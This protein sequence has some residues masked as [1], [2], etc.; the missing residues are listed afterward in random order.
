MIRKKRRFL[1]QTEEN[2][3]QCLVEGKFVWKYLS[4]KV[5]QK[6]GRKKKLLE[7]LSAYNPTGEYRFFSPFGWW[8]KGMYSDPLDQI[9]S[10]SL[11]DLITLLH[12]PIRQKKNSIEPSVVCFFKPWFTNTHPEIVFPLLFCQ[13]YIPVEACKQ[14]ASSTCI[15]HISN[16][17]AISDII[18]TSI[19]TDVRLPLTRDVIKKIGIRQRKEKKA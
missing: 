18:P 7:E 10:N 12:P 13:F 8:T 15:I 1:N 11:S 4:N 2:K 9:R 6:A 16:S 19:S 17:E 5:I 3:S 14:K